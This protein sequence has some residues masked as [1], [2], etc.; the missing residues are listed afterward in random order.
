MIDIALFGL[1]RIGIMHGKNLMRSKDFNLKYIYDIEQKLSKKYSKTLKTKA[2]NKP[3]VAYKDKN[4]KAIF[5]ASTTS[6]HIRFIL[7][8]VKNRK[9]IFCEKPLDLSIKKIESCKK[10]INKLN[11]KIQLGFNLSLIHI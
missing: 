6:T 1:G 5:I 2:I 4:I 3:S 9:I 8:G 7:D 11:P 10:K